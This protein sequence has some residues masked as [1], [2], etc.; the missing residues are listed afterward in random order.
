MIKLAAFADE[1]SSS[2]EGQIAALKRNEIEYI[3]L[4]GIDDKNISA[5]TLEEAQGYAKMLSDAGIK[6]WSIGSPIGKINI[7]DYSDEY[8]DKLRHICKLAKI[9]RT[10]KIRMFSFFEAY[11]QGDKV[12]SALCEMQKIA[13][14]EG[15]G[16]YHENEKSIY[17]DTLERVQEIMTKVNGMHYIYDPANYVEVGED[18]YTAINT[19]YEK[20]DYFHIKDV[21]ASTHELVPAGHGDGKISELIAKISPSEDKTL[22]LEP[23]LALFSG[24]SEIDATE[25]KNKFHFETND[26]AFDAAANAL[27]SLIEAQGY[28]KANGGYTK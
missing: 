5:V 6:V 11:E 24:Y 8:K 10:N 23:H 21:I 17:G 18:C 20:T 27:K 22:T 16:L 1:A 14:E 2:L 13:A 15:V 12:I 7:S 9:F 26:E 19:L 25:M 4:R 3:E 28:K